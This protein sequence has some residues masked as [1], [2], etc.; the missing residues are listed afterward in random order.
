M[1]QPFA[2]K[3]VFK[4]ATKSFPIFILFV[5]ILSVCPAI[6]LTVWSSLKMTMTKEK[7]L[8]IKHNQT[9]LWGDSEDVDNPDPN[10]R[11]FDLVMFCPFISQDNVDFYNYQVPIIILLA[12]NSIFLFWIMGVIKKRKLNF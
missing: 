1:L 9:S 7:L 4:I 12:F 6:I 11:V 2:F 8:Q 10:T 3:F 5:S